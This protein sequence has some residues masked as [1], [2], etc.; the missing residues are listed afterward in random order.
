MDKGALRFLKIFKYLNFCSEDELEQ[1]ED[2][3]LLT[4][5]IIDRIISMSEDK[6][7]FIYYLY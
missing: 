3:E 6:V 1:Y 4:E 2:E 5:L 7:Y